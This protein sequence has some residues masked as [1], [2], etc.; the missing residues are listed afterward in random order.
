MLMRNGVLNNGS[1]AAALNPITPKCRAMDDY[2]AH[3]RSDGRRR[4][5]VLTVRTSA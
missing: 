4:R 5:A 3:D 2:M 1:R